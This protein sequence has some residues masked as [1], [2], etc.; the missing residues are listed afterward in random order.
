MEKTLGINEAFTL[1]VLIRSKVS[2]KLKQLLDNLEIKHSVKEKYTSNSLDAFSISCKNIDEAGAI[3]KLI[4]LLNQKI[5][6]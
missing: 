6:Y 2:E 4:D 3:S 1:T 5:S